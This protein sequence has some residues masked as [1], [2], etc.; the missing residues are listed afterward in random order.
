MKGSIASKALEAAGAANLAGKAVIDA[1][2]PLADAPPENGVIKFFTSLDG[3]LMEQ[4]QKQFT[5]AY[6]VKAFNSVG[7]AVIGQ[8]AAQRWQ[9][10]HVHRWQ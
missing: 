5:G 6:F 10:F 7:A 8:S 3:S 4:L 9:T 2:N 1:T